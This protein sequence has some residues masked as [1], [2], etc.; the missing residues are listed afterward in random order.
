[1]LLITVRLEGVQNSAGQAERKH[2][3]NPIQTKQTNSGLTP[4]LILTLPNQTGLLFHAVPDLR[5]N[6]RKDPR[7]LFRIRGVF[8]F[9]LTS[10]W[11]H[12]F[13]TQVSIKIVRV[14]RHR[15][16]QG[17]GGKGGGSAIEANS[18]HSR[19]SGPELVLC[20]DF[21]I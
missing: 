12:A 17:R 18:D 16:E 5:Q 15:D 19:S 2:P 1:M 14:M 7:A 3:I 4:A 11:P 6:P 9:D 20:D 21:A 10:G 8:H 13:G